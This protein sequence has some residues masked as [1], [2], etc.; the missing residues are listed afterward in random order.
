MVGSNMQ[1]N[2]PPTALYEMSSNMQ[3][4]LILVYIVCILAITFT[5]LIKPTF[6]RNH[7]ENAGSHLDMTLPSPDR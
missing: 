7:L 6:L 1:V 4:E 3:E 5:T 2:G